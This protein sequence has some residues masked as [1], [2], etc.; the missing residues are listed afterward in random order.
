MAIVVAIAVGAA[1]F[2]GGVALRSWLSSRAAA[3][4]ELSRTVNTK[5][6]EDAA[7]EAAHHD[8]QQSASGVLRASSDDL[9][10]RVDE[11]RARG[12]AGK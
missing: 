11:L 12:R 8:A 4:V 7:A 3:I 5:P 6:A 9:R 1:L 2:L 10:R